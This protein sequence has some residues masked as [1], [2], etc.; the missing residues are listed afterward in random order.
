MGQKIVTVEVVVHEAHIYCNM[1]WRRLY[2][3][4]VHVFV[5]EA[6]FYMTRVLMFYNDT[7]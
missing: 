3:I 5:Q 1:T 7:W 2:D 6:E 4:C